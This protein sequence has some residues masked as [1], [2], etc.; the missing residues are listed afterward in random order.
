MLTPAAHGFRGTGHRTVSRTVLVVSGTKKGQ[1]VLRSLLEGSAY[2]PAAFAASGGEARR[3]LLSSSFDAVIVNAPLPDEFGTSLSQYA[4][5]EGT[6]VLLAVKNEVLDEVSARVSGF[7]VL[8]VGKPFSREQFYQALFLLDACR[9]RIERLESENAKLRLKMEEVRTVCRA[10]C[11]L[12]QYR[13]LTE[14]EAHKFIEK[15]AMDR[16]ITRLAVAQEI[17]REYGG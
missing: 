1:A 16:R 14:Q 5:E 3:V 13:G 11:L 15:E 9:N 12:V 10:K 17:L 6:G 8:T 2:R 7:G 4:A